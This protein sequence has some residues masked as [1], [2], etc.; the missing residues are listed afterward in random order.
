MHIHVQNS[1]ANQ[2]GFGQATNCELL[3]KQYPLYMIL[4]HQL[5]VQL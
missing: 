1:K 2:A 4:R 5:E 3:T